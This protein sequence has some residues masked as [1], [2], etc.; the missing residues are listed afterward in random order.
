MFV[1]GHL[2]HRSNEDDDKMFY[3]FN[4]VPLSFKGRNVLA[5]LDIK[6]AKTRN[7]LGK[8]LPVGAEVSERQVTNCQHTFV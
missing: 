1:S 2:T 5:F 7:R 4:L 6:S 3:L 8:P